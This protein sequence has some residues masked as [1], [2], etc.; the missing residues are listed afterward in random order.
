MG[1]EKFSPMLLES[2]SAAAADEHIPVIVRYR[3]GMATAAIAARAVPA[4]GRVGHVY[5]RIPARALALPA[6]EIAAY[7]DDADV[8]RV[9]PDL[10]VHTWLD[11]SVPLLQVPQVWADGH[12]GA[13]VKIAIV[14]TGIDTAHPDFESR[15]QA[16]RDFTGKGSVADGHGHG[17]HVAGIAA[18]SGAAGSGIYVGVAPEAL[19]YVAKVLSD[20]GGGM[21]S[22]VMAGIEWAVDEGAQVINL[23]LGAPGPGDGDDALSVLCDAAVDEGVIICAA[24]G[25]AGPGASTVGPP[26]VARKVITVGAS[27]KSDGIASFS[28]RG[29]T[30]DGRTKPDVVLPGV[31]IVAARASGTGMGSPVNDRYT[32]ASGTSMAT[33]HTTGAVALLLEAYPDLTPATVKDVL[34]R[35]AKDLGLDGNA[36]GAGRA[37]V[38]R[39][40]ASLEPVTPGPEPGPEPEPEPEPEPGPT[41][42][43]VGCLEALLRGLGLSK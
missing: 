30:A 22:D 12:R 33:P 24:A 7:A 1:V 9:W 43:P 20:D 32:S 41:P 35:S 39:A 8:E 6:G 14:D 4:D 16:S 15:I 42:E 26:G 2:V 31:S 21:M 10:P 17:T 13:G 34:M 25:N 11:D 23:S 3:A 28:S 29:P 27:D 19:L 40:Y 36:Q 18:G 38:Y 37:Q 5:R